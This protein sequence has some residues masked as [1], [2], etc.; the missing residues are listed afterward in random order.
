MLN[1]EK[2]RIGKVEIGMAPLIDCM[3]LLLIFFLLTSSFAAYKKMNVALPEASSTIK[4]NR[5][6]NIILLEASGTIILGNDKMKIED[7]NETL[8]LKHFGT[9]LETAVI[10]ADKEAPVKNLTLIMDSLNKIGIHNVA[11]ATANEEKKSS[12]EDRR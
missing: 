1:I 12:R 4:D 11:I 10:A 9:N 2:R 7:F 8:L 5:V 3:M 6:Q